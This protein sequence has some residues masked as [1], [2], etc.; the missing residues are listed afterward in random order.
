MSSRAKVQEAAR[1]AKTEID[2]GE[3][4]NAIADAIHEFVDYIELI[5]HQIRQVETRLRRMEM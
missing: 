1:R 4:L 3:K 2:H 5:E